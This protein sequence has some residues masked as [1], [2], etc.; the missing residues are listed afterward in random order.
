MPNFFCSLLYSEKEMSSGETGTRDHGLP[1]R[2]ALAAGDKRV[3]AVARP[4]RRRRLELRRLGRTASAAAE[5]EGAKRVRPVPDSS[6][7]SA[8]SAKVAPEPQKAAAARWPACVSHGAVSV[9]GRRREM[10]DAVA[11]AAPFL[12]SAGAAGEDKGGAGEGGKEDVGE[13]GF[14]AVYDGHGGSQVAEA[15][16]E[17]M[18]VVLAEEV[19]RLRQLQ[20]GGADEDQDGARWKEAMAACFARVDGEVGG[21]DE[22]DEDT[23]EQ[24]VGSTAVVAVVGPRRI[25]VANCGDSRAVLSRGGVAVPLSSDHKPD[26]P[27]ELERVEAA[28]GRVINWNGYRVLGVLATSRSIGP[29]SQATPVVVPMMTSEVTNLTP[30]RRKTLCGLGIWGLSP[31][32]ICDSGTRSDSYGPHG[33]RRVPH[34]GERRALGRRVQQG[35]LQDCKKLL[36]R[37]RGFQ[38]PG[39]RLREHGDR[40]GRAAGGARHV[41]RQQGQHQRRGGGVE[42]AEEPDGEQ[43]ER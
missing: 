20:R 14:F 22:G 30:M 25:V 19:V 5:E 6:S 36:E 39:V 33:Q 13:E 10:E 3:S 15:C 11:I 4:A 40:R 9:I 41:A 32:T 8:D 21:A 37:A 31:E 27:D 29:I 35:G 1:V 38:V 2:E 34:T 23:G 26:R 43:T 12:A 7:D 16:R 24:A 28:G 17:R 42:T 18:H